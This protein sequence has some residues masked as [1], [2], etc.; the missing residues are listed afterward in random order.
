MA[1]NPVSGNLLADRR[2]DLSRQFEER[3]DLE[4]AADL[5][6]QAL[7]LSPDWISARFFLGKILLQKGDREG[8]AKAFQTC[9]DIDPDDHMGARIKLSLL[10]FVKPLQSMPDAYVRSLFDEYAPRFD[11]ALVQRLHYRVPQ[12]MRAAADAVKPAGTQEDVL[13]LGCGTGL[14]GLAFQERAGRLDG[15][16]LSAAMLAEARAKKV[17]T[18]LYERDLL[19]FLKSCGTLYDIVLA[20]DV[21]VYVGDLTGVS[22]GV[23]AVLKQDGIFCFS[24]Q[25]MDGEDYALGADHRFSYSRP[26]IDKTFQERFVPVSVQTHVLRQDEGKDV[27]G[28]I[29]VLK[30]L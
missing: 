27:V 19:A 21:L 8:A 25:T 17:Y 12:I 7:D 15:V 29:W 11:Q 4:A 14:S 10:G 5:A 26:Y 13:D 9:L 18:S 3:G 20:A 1:F 24:V 30:A 16:D 2:L 6:A 23:H 28:D 22:E